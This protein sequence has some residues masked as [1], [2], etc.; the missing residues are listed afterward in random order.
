MV[1]EN[2]KSAPSGWLALAI[3]LPLLAGSAYF[4]VNALERDFLAGLSWMLL[5]IAA[6]VC[7]GGLFVVNPNQGVVL[8]LFG[9]YVYTAKNPG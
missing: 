6:A 5:L 9:D 2:A 3:L 7:L 4:M 1:Q 8:Q